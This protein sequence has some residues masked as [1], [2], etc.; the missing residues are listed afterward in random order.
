MGFRVAIVEDEEGIRDAARMLME[1]VGWS[2]EGYS[3]AEAFLEQFQDHRPPDCII[4][5]LSLP[6]MSGDTLLEQLADAA[7][8]VV[9]LTA[10]PESP[11]ATRAIEFGA[12]SVLAKPTVGRRLIEVITAIASRTGPGKR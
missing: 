7:I 6:G 12:E 10:Y 2:V 4:L 5:D 11:M 8:P 9:V 1:G 3:C